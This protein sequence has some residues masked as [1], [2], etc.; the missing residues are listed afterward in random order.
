[1]K[2]ERTTPSQPSCQPTKPVAGEKVAWATI[3]SISGKATS[4]A[5]ATTPS[6]RTARQALSR[7]FRCAL[8]LPAIATAIRTPSIHLGP[9]GAKVGAGCEGSV[10][11]QGRFRD[12]GGHVALAPQRRRPFTLLGASAT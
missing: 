4:T 3:R 11:V 7:Q 6:A 10:R 2:A 9:L 1:M 8:R 12:K 5:P